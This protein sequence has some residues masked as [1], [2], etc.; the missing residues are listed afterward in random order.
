MPTR[1][2]VQSVSNIGAGHFQIVVRAPNRAAVD[3]TYFRG[4]PTTLSSY[5]FADPFSD[6]VAVVAFPQVTIFDEIGSGEL[7]WLTDFA[8]VDIYWVPK[9]STYT[10]GGTDPRTKIWEGFIASMEWSQDGDQSGLTIQCQGALFQ[11]D[12]HLSF[13]SYPSRPVTYESMIA[14]SFSHLIYPDFRTQELKIEWPA[15]WNKQQQAQPVLYMPFYTNVGQNITGFATRN[16][17]SFDR[18]LTSYIQG[19]LQVMIDNDYGRQWTIRKDPNRQPVL[20]L[21]DNTTVNYQVMAGQPGITLDLS[22]DLQ[23]YANVIYGQ[24]TD[25]NGVDYNMAQ[26]SN[27]GSV[28]TYTPMAFDPSVYPSDTTSNPRYDHSKMRVD[29]YIKYD[30]GFDQRQAILA[31]QVYLSRDGDPGYMGTLTLTADPLDANGNPFSRFLMKAGTNILVKYVLGSGASGKLFHIASVEIDVTSGT[32]SCKID[33]KWRD[34]LTLEE[35]LVRTRDVLT[36][37]N[38]L[39]INKRSVLIE[40]KLAPWD[41]SAG[42]GYVPRASTKFY[43]DMPTT[44]SFPYVNHSLKY[45]PKYH[46]EFYIKCAANA[47]TRAGRWAIPVPILMSEKGTIRSVQVAAFDSN[48]NQLAIPFHFSLYYAVVSTDNMPYDANGPSP[49]IANA[50]ESTDPNGMP[51]PA[52]SYP[53]MPQ[54]SLIIGWGNG[55]QPAGYSPGSKTAGDPVTGILTDDATWTFDLTNNP[56]FIQNPAAGYR[57]VTAATTIYGAFYAEYFDFVYFRGRFYRQEPG[58]G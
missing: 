56:D 32:V 33:T 53:T 6:S 29:T 51:I 45:P 11:A 42:S 19:L 35:A 58:T 13:P 4:V 39:Q 52:G 44:E 57:Q 36:P 20:Y 40:D 2:Q 16:T 26:V 8:D 17:G 34:L 9:G 46:P 48:G 7:S 15:G 28:T 21:R 50:F 55:V 18:L 30:N 23:Q 37:V 1:W 12:K 54:Q 10:P 14:I 25:V 27:D 5:S 41:Y 31:S 3:V 22:R 49:F 47:P 43:A 38:M 24:G